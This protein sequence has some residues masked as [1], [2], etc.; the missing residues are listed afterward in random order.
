MT[1]K[2]TKKELHLITFTLILGS[3]I[4][5]SA[6]DM[7][8]P[9]LP[10]IAKTF[11]TDDTLV[12]L[13]VS[14]GFYG[15]ASAGLVY[16]PLA[17]V[18]GRKRMLIAGLT[19]FCVASIWCTFS[20]NIYNLIVARFFQGVGTV[21]SSVLW[22]TIVNDIF[23][24]K[25]LVGLLGVF[26]TTISLTLATA[27]V[28]GA[29]IANIFG[30]RGIFGFLSLASLLQ[31]FLIY[32]NIPETLP[33]EARKPVRA[34]TILKNYKKIFSSLYFI[35]CG[36]L[37]GSVMGAYIGYISVA[38]FYYMQEM[39]MS[40]NMFVV[41]QFVPVVIYSISAW[42]SRHVVKHMDLRLIF[43][44][45]IGAMLTHLAIFTLF[46]VFGDPKVITASYCLFSLASPFLTGVV[47]TVA[48]NYF[49]RMGGT[50]SSAFTTMRQLST[51]LTISFFTV[52]YNDNFITIYLAQIGIAVM[53][54]FL[55][56]WIYTKATKT[57]NVHE[58]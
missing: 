48:M 10:D 37:N 44:F 7:N 22:L 51:A 55:G 54:L 56:Y 41:H 38:S 3:I 30:W 29:N 42:L 35:K 50:S 58:S 9:V 19:I 26:S 49:P 32:K 15:T 47:T 16:G 2:Y 57:F 46:A 18:L 28:V 12:Q 39:G 52:M 8:I 17:D 14:A 43:V 21:A 40:Q 53:I 45:G 27:P 11:F 4:V 34:R 25:E 5:N 31:V 20:V 6:L 23:K 36:A 33:P 1:Q 24:G 13:S